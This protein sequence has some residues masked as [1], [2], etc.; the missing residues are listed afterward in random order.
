MDK[1]LKRELFDLIADDKLDEAI[2]KLQDTLPMDHPSFMQ[3]IKLARRFRELERNTQDA[4]IALDDASLAK[5][6]ISHSLIGILQGVENRRTDS[7]AATPAPQAQEN[8]AP[9]HRRILPRID[10]PDEPSGTRERRPPPTAADPSDDAAET[11]PNFSTASAAAE[12]KL[13]FFGDVTYGGSPSKKETVIELRHGYGKTYQMCLEATKQ[14]GFK[15][16][17]ADR[18][19]G[20]LTASSPAN[21]I[22]SFGEKL[23]FFLTPIDRARTRIH[24]IVDAQLPTTV[25]DWGRNKNKLNAVL[26]H[27]R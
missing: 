16:E 24:I 5:N 14:A 6:Q 11:E 27:L 25:F 20:Q 2:E 3:V 23:L 8:P 4:I 22:T 9:A 18:T 13:G 1:Q 7:S 26:S 15:M 19:G 12:G 21:F 17:T 10:D